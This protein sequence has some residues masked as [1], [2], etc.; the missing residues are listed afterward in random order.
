[1]HEIACHTYHCK[2]INLCIVGYGRP[3]TPIRGV[4]EFKYQDDWIEQQRCLQAAKRL[5]AQ[6][7]ACDTNA[8]L[9]LY[10]TNFRT[11][12]YIVY[13]FQLLIYIQCKSKACK[14]KAFYSIFVCNF[15]KYW[16]VL[17]FFRCLS[18]Q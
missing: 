2:K 15:G 5:K 7:K 4:L 14:S 3:S 18:Q 12:F 13:Y 1:M 8:I 6:A 10:K 16:L 17:T 9:Q 11:L